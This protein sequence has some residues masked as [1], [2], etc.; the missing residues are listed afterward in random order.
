VLGVLDPTAWPAGDAGDA[1]TDEIDRLVRER[2]EARQRRDFKESD[3]LRNELTD[4]G[5]V[6]EDTPQGTRWKRK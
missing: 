5:I 1:D 4:R 6:L 2:E 3:R